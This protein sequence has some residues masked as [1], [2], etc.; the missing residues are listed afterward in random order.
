MP[1][2]NCLEGMACPKCKSEGPFRIQA[3]TMAFVDDDGVQDNTDY[4]WDEASFCCCV[5]CDHTGDV[6]DFTIK[7]EGD[8]EAIHD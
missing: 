8:E 5:E 2:E 4:E 3:V 1:N 6:A 7:E